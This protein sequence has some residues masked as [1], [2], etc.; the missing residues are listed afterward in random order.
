MDVTAVDH[1]TSESTSGAK[2]H[3]FLLNNRECAI[4]PYMACQLSVFYK[5]DY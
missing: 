2:S 4:V 3:H 5:P 1:S